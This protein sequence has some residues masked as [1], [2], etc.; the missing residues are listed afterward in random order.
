MSSIPHKTISP[1]LVA[2]LDGLRR[3]IRSYIWVDGL[4]AIVV[5]L[6]LAFWLSLGL[7]WV[8]EPPAPL[9]LSTI[10]AVGLGVVW[11]LYRVIFRRAFVRLADRSMALLLERR[12]P[13]L[14]DSLLTV[15]EL[16]DHEDPEREF[17]PEMIAETERVA[18]AGAQHVRLGAVFNTR[19]LLRRIGFAVLL[20][21]SVIGFGVAARDAFGLWVRRSLLLSNEL[22]PRKTRLM[23]D[24]FDDQPSLKVARGSDVDLSV[25]ADAAPGRLVPDVV[26]VRY[27]SADGARVR[28]NMSRQGEVIVGRD[29][30]QPYGYTFKGVLAP[31]D[32][33]VL[34]GDDRRGPFHLDV[35]DSPTVKQMT[36]HCEYPAYMNRAPREIPV[37]GIMPVPRGTRIVI[38]AESNKNLQEVQ[39]DQV[40]D[41]NSP[42]TMRWKIDAAGTARQQ[43]ELALEKFNTEATLLFTL[44]DT[45]SIKSR[46]PLRLAISAV[47]DEAPQVALRLS[48]IGTAITPQARL[49]LAGEILDDY[50]IGAAWFEFR[51]D[52]QQPGKQAFA[53]EPAGRD[54]MRV[55]EALE[56]GPLELQ[57]KQKLSL[58]VQAADTY[59]LAGEPNVGSGAKYVLDVVTPAQLR[60]M[61]EARELQLRRRFET[62]MQEFTDTRDLLARLDVSGAPRVQ[63]GDVPPSSDLPSPPQDAT[64]TRASDSQP[65]GDEPGDE[66][67][68]VASSAPR[69][70]ETPENIAAGRKVQAARVNQ[71]SSRSADE[72]RGL[73][74]AFD[75]IRAELVN[76]RVD[77]EELKKRL[78]DGI[79]DPLRRISDA[80]FPELLER[81]KRLENVVEKP[82]EASA[83]QD[84]A[85][86]QADIILVE[87]QQV[88]DNMLELETF[89]EVLDLL[90]AIIKSQE[91]LNQ[92]TRDRQKSKL[93]DLLEE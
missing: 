83:A 82:A 63:E 60:T 41:G 74:V 64:P 73:A 31:I 71:N 40:L 48:G 16:A 9:R 34:G 67:G 23:V 20:L 10:G 92:Q 29:D 18:L 8:F 75:D 52:Q 66:P 68:D 25:K 81:L 58:V 46:D 49:P 33:Y 44:L 70:A 78:K 53:A 27:S 4:A 6:G 1:A 28:D 88:L 69:A 2:L 62:I 91:E 43:F 54:K 77:T 51:V 76:N 45:D 61:L 93:R 72:T 42:T 37:T 38:R 35:V 39:V 57:P 50:A 3:R 89:N 17:N 14:D 13:S 22:W 87:M 7:D 21:A 86:Q 15:V 24:R 56:V 80:R 5:L 55:D 30:V 12:F 19:P 79:A 11:L 85:R 90:R 65:P 47:A 36:L 59:D 32:F 84:A 26:E